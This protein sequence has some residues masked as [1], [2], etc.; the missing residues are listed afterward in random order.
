MP[1][2]TPMAT[3]GLTASKMQLWSHSD[4][5]YLCESK[6]GSRAGGYHFLSDPPKLPICD[7]DPPPPHNAPILVISKIIDAVMSSAQEAETAAGFINGKE[8]IPS[9]RVLEEMGH[10]QLPVPIQFDNKVATAIMNDDCKQKQSKSMYMRFY[11]LRCG[12]RRKQFHMYWKRGVNTST[13]EINLADYP[14][15][16]HPTK[17]HILLRPT[18][19]LNNLQHQG[20]QNPSVLHTQQLHQRNFSKLH[21][22]NDPYK[23]TSNGK[24]FTLQ[25]Q[26]L[27]YPFYKLHPYTST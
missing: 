1:L 7:I 6:A 15:K 11:W 4:A 21:L 14:T 27:P 19:V 22:R 25:P 24:H 18:Y 9:I 13:N 3:I 2:R 26:N 23:P 17:H 12:Q 20:V 8:L 16:Q 10:K 5:S